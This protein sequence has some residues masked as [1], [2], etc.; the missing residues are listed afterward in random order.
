ML[1]SLL[2]A[3]ATSLGRHFAA[4]RVTSF[5]EGG[6]GH[7]EWTHRNGRLGDIHSLDDRLDHDVHE[8]MA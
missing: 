7:R 5:V 4:G 3:S 6:K 1:P 8:L 2:S